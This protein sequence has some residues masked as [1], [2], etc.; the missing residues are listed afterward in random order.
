MDVE[1]TQKRQQGK[2][3]RPLVVIHRPPSSD[4]PFRDRLER[5]FNLLDPQDHYPN[6]THLF[7]LNNAR[8]ARVLLYL[9]LPTAISKEL[10][11]LLPS[12]QLIVGSSSGVDHVDLT[13]CRRRGIQVT[14]AGSAFSE[15]VADYAVGLLID[16]LRKISSADRF[17]RAGRWPGQGDYPLGFKLGK[18]RIGIVGLGNIGSEVAK[19][20]VSFGCKISYT[21]RKKKPFVTFPYYSNVGDL[22]TNSDVLI[23]CCALTEET[24]HMINKDV[25]VALG[26]EGVIVN[27][28]RGELIDEK[29]LVRLLARGEVGGAGLDVFE[30]EPQVPSELSALDNVVLSPHLAF[31]TPECIDAVEEL[32]MY[33]LKAFFEDKPLR[34]VVKLD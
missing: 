19:R 21:S 31:A 23:L 34:S 18:K 20:I 29:E 2:D 16:V 4:N 7:L 22:A 28:G 9:G 1:E 11:S 25:M 10:L 32:I 6:P 13:E 33:N 17:V 3:D 30:N 27:V 5:H 24:Y 26:K 14:N 8:T 15:D 12:L